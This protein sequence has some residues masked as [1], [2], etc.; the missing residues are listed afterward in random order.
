MR[1]S[2]SGRRLRKDSHSGLVAPAEVLGDRAGSVGGES[3]AR[4][5]TYG[6]NCTDYPRLVPNFWDEDDEEDES[7]LTQCA[8]ARDL[9][10]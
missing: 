2:G 1:G 6:T 8:V 9:S 7:D 10:T 4:A 3:S 5:E